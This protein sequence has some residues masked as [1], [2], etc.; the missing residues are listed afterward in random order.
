MFDYIVFFLLNGPALP[1]I[2]AI[3][4]VINWLFNQITNVNPA[5]KP[6]DKA[7]VKPDEKPKE[8]GSCSLFIII[9][10]IML[11]LFIYACSHGIPFYDYSG[12][13]Y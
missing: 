4:L 11:F 6:P 9:C 2:I 5:D 13:R 8:E 12:Y 3:A 1:I 7:T 10:L